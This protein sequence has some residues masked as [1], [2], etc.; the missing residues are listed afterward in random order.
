MSKAPLSLRS[1]LG[2]Y[3]SREEIEGLFEH[4]PVP[5]KTRLALSEEARSST[6][7]M[8]IGEMRAETASKRIT[9]LKVDPPSAFAPSTE[10]IDFVDAAHAA[11]RRG[12]LNRESLLQ[13]PQKSL[14][15]ATSAFLQRD[16]EDFGIAFVGATGTGKT[17]AIRAIQASLPR[18]ID[19]GQFGN[20]NVRL[21]QFPVIRVECP[22][23]AAPK[24]L[25]IQ[26]IEAICNHH[27]EM[28][29]T[30]LPTTRIKETVAD[31]ENRCARLC[32]TFAIGLIVIDN[33]E[34]LA[35]AARSLLSRS[36]RRIVNAILRLRSKC[37]VPFALCGNWSAEQLL[38]VDVRSGR[39]FADGG[40]YFIERMPAPKTKS[41]RP[42]DFEMLVRAKWQFLLVRKQPAP[43]AKM[44]DALYACTA[45]VPAFLQAL[46]CKVQIAALSAG[47]EAF[48]EALVREVYG[49]YLRT[50]RKSVDIAHGG[51]LAAQAA[52]PD[53]FRQDPGSREATRK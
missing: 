36:M 13:F 50:V 48:D 7:H 51:D 42:S 23:D 11:I 28:L 19:H 16:N 33:A 14:Y 49:R 2:D 20:G 29:G 21:V 12:Y 30:E 3:P 47:L 39:R 37:A 9:R 15:E 31:L 18:F 43:T 8:S 41:A 26:I 10:H 4:R 53:L 45:G 32:S 44:I 17:T 35:L 38:D 5:A 52:F 46:L 25:P 6:A 40:A 1:A 27:K 24:D 34:R 22:D